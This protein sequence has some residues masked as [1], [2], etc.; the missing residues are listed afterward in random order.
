MGTGLGP[1]KENISRYLIT[2]E[3]VTKNVNL[4]ST[5]VIIYFVYF[6]LYVIFPYPYSYHEQG[7]ENTNTKEHYLHSFTSNF[8]W[9][10]ISTSSMKGAH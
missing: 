10:M 6:K 1:G 4:N 2:L 9:R 5:S 7:Y 8:L 3:N